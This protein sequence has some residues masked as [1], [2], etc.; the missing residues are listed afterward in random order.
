ML[1][2]GPGIGRRYASP[3][4]YSGFS[5]VQV[6]TLYTMA[7]TFGCERGAHLHGVR[8]IALDAYTRSTDPSLLARFVD[9]CNTESFMGFARELTG[10]DDIC[11]VGAQATCFR[12]GH[13][14]GFHADAEEEDQQRATCVFNFTPHWM[15]EWGGLLQFKNEND[16]ITDVFSPSFN[17]LSVFGYSQDYAVSAVT[18]HC[19]ASRYAIAVALMAK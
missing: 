2:G 9:F 13:F 16:Q 15:A 6:Q 19:P 18:P 10:A 3:E 1:K 8:P 12:A 17:S 5:P 11:R 4:Q 7:H 14:F